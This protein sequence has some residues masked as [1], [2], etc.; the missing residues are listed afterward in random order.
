[1]EL[2]SWRKVRTSK[3]LCSP[4]F[5][6]KNRKV[7]DAIIEAQGTSLFSKSSEIQGYFRLSDINLPKLLFA[8]DQPNVNKD[9]NVFVSDL[10]LEVWFK[11]GS[12]ESLS[13]NAQVIAPKISGIWNIFKHKYK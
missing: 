13:F 9:D 1:M 3:G 7:G 4:F 10:N 11:A 5:D 2:L 6:D 12:Q 8:E